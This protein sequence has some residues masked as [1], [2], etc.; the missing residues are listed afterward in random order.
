MR[1]TEVVQGKRS[2]GS[3]LGS[4][5]LYSSLSQKVPGLNSELWCSVFVS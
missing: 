3:G 4:S 5:D 1:Q 2:G